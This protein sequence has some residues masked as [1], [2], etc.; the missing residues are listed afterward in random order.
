MA[1]PSKQRGTAAE[2]SAVRYLRLNGF[3]GA[4]RQPLRGNKDA[5]DIAL[6][7]GVVLEV[8]A[9]RSASTGQPGAAQL[10]K[11]MAESEAERVNAGALMC[12]LVVKRSGTADPGRW[13]VF[14]TART[15]SDL[16][17]A[18]GQTVLPDPSAPVCMALGSL[19]AL[20]RG[21]GYG[22]PLPGTDA[23]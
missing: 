5:G 20:L 1:N 4:D 8:K 23:A 15:C 11:W 12:P 17:G 21:A 3:S 6:C 14:I 22:S 18:P 9:H 13:W 7:P 10:A 2:T 16:M 19:V